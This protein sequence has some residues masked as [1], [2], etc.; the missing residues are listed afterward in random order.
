VR[1]LSHHLHPDPSRAV[2][3]VTEAL[4]GAGWRPGAA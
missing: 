3:R 2:A 1:I 4:V